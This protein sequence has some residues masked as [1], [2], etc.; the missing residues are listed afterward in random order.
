MEN[1]TGKAVTGSCLGG[2]LGAI[3]GVFL[4]GW[5]AVAIFNGV[6]EPPEPRNHMHFFDAEDLARL[7]YSLLWLV[8]GAVC[9]GILGALGGSMLGVISASP[10]PDSQD[11]AGRAAG[12]TGLP[13][14]TGP[15]DGDSDR[16]GAP[17]PQVKV[18]C[19]K[20]EALNDETVRFCN[21]CGAAI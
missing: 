19:R 15:R 10:D 16:P 11:S 20:C 13:G 6:S 9:G 12:P 21:Q 4:G 7:G 8:V 17:Q 3:P 18:R 5:I 2:L 1:Q 14:R